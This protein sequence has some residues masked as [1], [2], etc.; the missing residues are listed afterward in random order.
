MTALMVV[1]AVFLV[2]LNGFFVAAEFAFVKVRKTRLELLAQGGHTHAKMALFGVQNLDAYLSVCQLGITLASLGLGWIGEPAI[3][4]L[5]RPLLEFFSINSPILLTAISVAVGFTIIT[6]MHVVLGELM[7]KSIAIQQAESTVLVLALPL[8][9]FYY[10]SLPLVTIMNGISNFLLRQCGFHSVGESEE[11]H[12]REELRMLIANSSEGGEVVPSEG[13]M[14]SNI[15]SFY[16]KTAK[17]AM[18]HRT[19][20][21]VLNLNEGIDAAIVKAQRSGHTRFPVYDK[22]EDTIAGFIHVKDLLHHEK[23]VELSAV[24]RNA[25]FVHEMLTLD[26]LLQQMK[27]KKQQLCIVFDE[28]GVWQGIVTMED[29]VESIVG[30]I[31]DE[32]DNEL[33]DFASQADGSALVSADLSLDDIAQHMPLSCEGQGV[34]MHKIIAAHILEQLEQIPSVGDSI[35]LCGKKFTVAIMDRQRIRRVHV[36]DIGETKN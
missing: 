30:D 24:L 32:F 6:F 20:V 34:N 15:F 27:E 3:A 21:V 29:L 16:Q 5:V 18:I 9:I 11:H 25:L 2:L 14:L 33:P 4:T 23:I 22:M 35:N 10:L 8:K 13:K 12:S 1:L 7:P 19:D 31:Q 17:D 26:K 36:K 28:Y